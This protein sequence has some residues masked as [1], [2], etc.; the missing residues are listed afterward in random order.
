MNPDLAAQPTLS[1]P[2]PPLTLNRQL[3]R[4]YQATT[5]AS[6]VIAALAESGQS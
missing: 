2:R 6:P 3:L 5:M 4:G 1:P